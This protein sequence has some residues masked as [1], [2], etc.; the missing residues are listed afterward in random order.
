MENICK[1]LYN[2][3]T[4]PYEK[5]KQYRLK[6]LFILNGGSIGIDWASLNCGVNECL[7]FTLSKGSI[8]MI[9]N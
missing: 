8:K 5:K 2:R 7:K 9:D 1:K 6:H 4:I 3:E